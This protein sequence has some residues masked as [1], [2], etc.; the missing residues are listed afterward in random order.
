MP[1]H[2]LWHCVLLLT[3]FLV[4]NE[5]LIALQGKCDQTCAYVREKWLEL[6][7][8]KEILPLY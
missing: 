5:G 4:L 2:K 1:K 7:I 6:L 3:F 8:F